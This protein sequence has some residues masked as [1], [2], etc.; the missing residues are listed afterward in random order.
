MAV[1]PATVLRPSSDL[2]LVGVRDESTNLTGAA[3][4]RVADGGAVT[5]YTGADDT[6]YI[7]AAAGVQYPNASAHMGLTDM[8]AV[9]ATQR[10]KQVRIRAR[11]RMNS[12]VTG[13]AAIIHF[14]LADPQAGL[15]V[16]PPGTSEQSTSIDKVETGSTTVQTRTGAWHTAPPPTNGEEWTAAIVNRMY[17][18]VAWYYGNYGSVNLRLT[19]VYVD[20]D[21]R[22]RPGVSGVTATG[23]A[24]T[25]RPIISWT[26]GPN[27]DGDPQVAYQLRVFTSAQ[28][29]IAGFDPATSPATWNS[30]LKYGNDSQAPVGRDLANGATYKVYTR[31]AQDFNGERWWSDWAASSP[32]T[33]G[34]TVPP[35]PTLAV[36]SDTTVPNLRNVLTLGAQLN[37]LAADDADFETT[38][39]NWTIGA[40]FSSVARSTAQARNGVGSL[41]VTCTGTANPFT[42][43]DGNSAAGAVATRPGTTHTL[44]GYARANTTGRAWRLVLRW[45][46]A[47]RAYLSQTN[48]STVSDAS[49]T[50]TAL[51]AVTGTAPAGAVWVTAQIE[52]AATPAAGEVHYFDQFQLV[53]G[54]SV[55]AWAPGFL[56]TSGPVI[57]RALAAIDARNL[58]S[59]QLYSGGD[60]TSS[61]DGFYT[62]GTTSQ[63]TWDTSDRFQGVGSI[64][65]EVEDTTAVLYCGLPATAD[66]PAPVYALV[67]VPGRVAS[68]SLYAR[69][70]A[71]FTARIVLE[72]LDK[73]LNILGSFS[74]GDLSLTTSWQRFSLANWTIG[75]S[76]VYVRPKL[77]NQAAVTGRD[78]WVDGLQWELGTSPSALAQPGGAPLA[79][80]PVR[81]YVPGASVMPGGAQTIT[82][83]DHEVAPGF[84]YLY[85][86]WVFALDPTSGQALSSA[87]S[88]YV[89]ALID[90]PG[91]GNWVLSEVAPTPLLR[92]RVCVLGQLSESQDEDVTVYH[93][94]RPARPGQFGLRPVALS[95][96][97][98]G[99]D[100]QLRLA[101]L[102]EDNW[103]LLASLLERTEALWFIEA[104]GGARY[105]RLTDRSWTRQRF[106][107]GCAVLADGSTL[108]TREWERVLQVS[109]VE[110]DRPPDEA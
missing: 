91:A 4:T 93:P 101:A 67:G 49:G 24:T 73:D 104:Q 82:A 110:A 66:D 84:T 72:R 69:A 102:S 17:L 20:V 39:G 57:E 21:V 88:S 47:N 28:Y 8:A 14:K 64:H 77:T 9:G 79:W 26:Y 90:P 99:H 103:L 6:S 65:W 7:Y 83:M 34:L 29:G 55:P 109:Y 51:A 58:A 2:K 76:T 62:T 16:P 36:A 95:D 92:G 11:V 10:I 108:T 85:R 19:E 43:N 60:D 48:G 32:F 41:A 42:A 23:A 71:A 78:V 81:G 54:A 56:A 70:D 106:R 89:S 40:G 63:V 87:Y 13:D 59:P 50:W 96:W 74:S 75:A 15:G 61:A 80:E 30:G 38:V 105:I 98:G 46:D 12:L 5:D 97:I 53:P 94:I 22:D 44:A 68:F 1:T 18:R 37:A 27:V 25:T 100:G 86:A 33:I 3:A 35:T 52:M 107:T 45:L 31:V